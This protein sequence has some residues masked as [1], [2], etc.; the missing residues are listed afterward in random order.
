M[1]TFSVFE[2][3]HKH[4]LTDVVPFASDIVLQSAD[5]RRGIV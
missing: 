5:Q 3:V 4:D 1:C 2:I